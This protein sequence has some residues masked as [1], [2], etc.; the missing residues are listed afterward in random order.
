MQ[1]FARSSTRRPVH[2]AVAEVAPVQELHHALQIGVTQPA[3]DLARHRRDLL[4]LRVKAIAA[5]F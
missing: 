3:R 5:I 1:N 2:V 4:E